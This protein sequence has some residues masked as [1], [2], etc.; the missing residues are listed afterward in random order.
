ML[1]KL[2]KSKYVVREDVACYEVSVEKD[3]R[4]SDRD[5]DEEKF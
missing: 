3:D 2:G 1:T 5:R 4:D